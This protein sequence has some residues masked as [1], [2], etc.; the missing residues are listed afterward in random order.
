MEMKS[1]RQKKTLLALMTKSETPDDLQ[2]ALR[3]ILTDLRH[4]TD[5]NNLDFH[6]ALDGSY[7][8][9]CKERTPY[10]NQ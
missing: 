5:A 10:A 2:S 7:V 6:S 9:Y 1:T 3:D 8:A 4:I